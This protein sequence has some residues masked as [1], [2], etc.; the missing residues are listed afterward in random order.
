MKTLL[1]LLLLAPALRASAAKLPEEAET[2]LACHSKDGGAPLTKLDGYARS[3]H[4]DLS[5]TSCHTQ[6]GEQPHPK[7]TKPD[8][9]TCHDGP[10]AGVAGSPHGAALTARAGSLSGACKLCHG[11]PHAV[12]KKGDPK[13]PAARVN[14]MATCGSCHGDRTKTPEAIANREPVKSYLT[15]VHG[16]AAVHGSTRAASCADCHG[17]HEIRLGLDSRS[18]VNKANI[19]DTC[20]RC[21]TSQAEQYRQSVHGKALAGGMKEAP[22]CT[23]CHGEHTVRSPS[24]P[25]SSVSSGAVTNTCSNC[26]ASEKLIGQFKLPP[27]QV[28]SFRA[29]YHGLAAQNGKGL[30]VANCASCHGWHD[31]LPSA[32]PAS[33]VNPANVSRTCGQCHAGAALRLGTGKVHQALS[34]SGEGSAAANF[35]KVFYLLAIPMTLGGML[36]HNLLDLAHKT[37]TGDLRPMRAEEEPMLTPSERWQHAGLVVSFTLLAYSGFALKFPGHFWGAP[38]EWL[39]GEEFRRQAHRAAAVLFVLVSAV[40]AAYLAVAVKGRQR[41]LALLPAW[42]DLSDPPAVLAYN[43]GLSKKRPAMP[44]FSY[45]EKAEYWALV[46]GSGVMLVT[47]AVL[48]FD[49]LSLKVLPLWAIESARVIHFMEA[50]LACLAILVWHGYWVAFDPE[51]YPLNWAWLTGKVRLGRGGHGAHHEEKP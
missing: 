32:D 30:K 1:L 4:A 7:M 14:Q 39:G 50:V 25:T 3:A 5:C 21:H 6:A 48:V 36:F 17:A 29:S 11:A 10:A 15:T 22:T 18:R 35:F 27:G 8:C 43:A 12:V 44:R 31:I 19:A 24:D 46:W 38:F 49:T 37:L 47:G 51:V 20:G 23:D 45:I 40:H 28:R 42:R 26:H 13:S 2:C 33:H 41:L 34:G 16:A 9:G